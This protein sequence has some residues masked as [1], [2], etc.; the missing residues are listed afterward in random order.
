MKAFIIG[1]GFMD[2][3]DFHINLFETNKPDYIIYV[4]M[5]VQDT[6]EDLDL[7]LIL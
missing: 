7:S 3:D 1:N 4:L 2:N 5:G 6:Y